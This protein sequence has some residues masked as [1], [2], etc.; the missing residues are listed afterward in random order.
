MANFAAMSTYELDKKYCSLMDELMRC[1][2][3]KVDEIQ[4]MIYQIE[5][6]IEYRE[7]LNE[8]ED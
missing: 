3:D 4:E 6:E 2:D 7:S 8:E 5:D 1:D